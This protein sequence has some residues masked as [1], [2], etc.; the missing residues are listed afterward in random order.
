L[1]AATSGA[2]S[3]WRGGPA[4]RSALTADLRLDRV[5][6]GDAGAR[7]LG[8]RCGAG[9]APG[10][11]H[12]P[13]DGIAVALD[14]AAIAGGRL[15]PG[16]SAGPGHIGVKDDAGRFGSAPRP[17]LARD[18]PEHRGADRAELWRRND[19]GWQRF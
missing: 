3:A 15:Q 9:L 2:A 14:D 12:L 7:F 19:P 8:E 4:H 11:S 10:V 13:V 16:R 18:R 6:C 17:A 5:K 1:S